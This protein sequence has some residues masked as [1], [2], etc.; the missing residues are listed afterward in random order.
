MTGAATPSAEDFP[1]PPEIE[2]VTE[3]TQLRTYEP[4]RR[5][6]FG[7]VPRLLDISPNET[8]T[9]EEADFNRASP[10]TLT[11]VLLESG[12]KQGLRMVDNVPFSS[13]EFTALV[14]SPRTVA[15]R[16]GSFALKKVKL[17][18]PDRQFEIDYLAR[19]KE[20]ERRQP[21]QQKVV[22]GLHNEM[23]TLAELRKYAQAPGR[24]LTTE[25]HLRELALVAWQI[26]DRMLQEVADRQSWSVEERMN[27]NQAM[28][29]SFSEGAQ[30]SRVGS[31]QRYIDVAYRYTLRK[32]SVFSRHQRWL[33]QDLTEIKSQL[34]A[35][36]ERT[37]YYEL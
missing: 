13:D 4:D 17:A 22:D 36:Y 7:S 10:D 31:W 16:A 34:D 30:R 8:I 24:A 1:P 2:V 33:E 21:V 25:E 19:R 6:A 18:N 9:V 5:R 11:T 20:L 27:A 12:N 37:G 32:F 15:E 29:R 14:L 26:F 3:V 23:R 28:L 35:F